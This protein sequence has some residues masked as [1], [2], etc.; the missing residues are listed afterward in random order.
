MLPAPFPRL[1]VF[2]FLL[3]GLVG[4]LGACALGFLLGRRLGR[5]LEGLDL[6]LD[7][8]LDEVV[9]LLVGV[10]VGGWVC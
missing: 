2:V 5:L 3:L 4:L 6:D 7:L 10:G 9:L 1:S 8:G